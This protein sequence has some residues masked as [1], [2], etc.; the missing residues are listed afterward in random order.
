MTLVDRSSQ[1]LAKA[2]QADVHLDPLRATPVTLA[3]KVKTAFDAELDARL[4]ARGIVM[5]T[6]APT[7]EKRETPDP[8]AAPAPASAPTVKSR[9]LIVLQVQPSLY[10]A[11]VTTVALG[12]ALVVLVC[13]FGACV[14]GTN[15]APRDGSP[16]W[17]PQSWSTNLAI[18]GA[19]LT[20]F[21][22]MAALPAYTHYA[23]KG[24]YSVLSTFYTAL[25]AAAPAIYGLLKAGGTP[26]QRGAMFLFT[27]AAAVTVWATIGQLGMAGMLFLE[28][29][30]ARLLNAPAA[31][32]AVYLAGG[33][34][35]L[36]LV[37]A[38]RAVWF[39][40]TTE[41]AQAG[42]PVPPPGGGGATSWPLL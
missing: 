30:E 21:V 1:E 13:G 18:G 15:A 9:D 34:A 2:T 11:R 38:L 6:A 36:V 37:H 14:K 27:V 5:M 12:A 16:A 31:T 25:I 23:A 10:E 33:T 41:P 22:G 20:S 35:V 29:R 4:P 3:L 7:V 32:A 26:S 42:A 17:T 19:L 40:A 24:N 28:L 39:Y 8:K